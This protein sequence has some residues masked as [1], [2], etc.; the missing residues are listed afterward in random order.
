MTTEEVLFLLSVIVILP[1]LFKLCDLS[2]II[3][4]LV[5]FYPLA[6]R[7]NGGKYTKTKG[8]I[9]MACEK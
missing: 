3:H 9:T 8:K 4:K 7:K 6:N 2:F 1:L 5:R